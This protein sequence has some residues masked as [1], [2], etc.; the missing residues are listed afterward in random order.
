MLDRLRSAVGLLLTL[1]A[2][3]VAVVLIVAGRFDQWRQERR[4]AAARANTAKR[5]EKLRQRLLEVRR[6]ADEQSEAAAGEKVRRIDAELERDRQRDPVE[7][8]NELVD[9][10][11]RGRP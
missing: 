3:L 2:G 4:E 8:A 10:A 7:V 1:L 5:A 11:R 6:I 9:E